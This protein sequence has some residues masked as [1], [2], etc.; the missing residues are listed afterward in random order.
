MGKRKG[1]LRG[2]R[3]LDLTQLYPGPLATMMLADMGAEVVRLEHPSRPDNVHHLPPFIGKE[4]AAYLTLNRSKRSLAL[5]TAKE[6]GRKVFFDL[7]RTADV[8][9]EQFRP[10]VLDKIGIGY[11]QAVPFNSR[12]IYVSITGFGQDGPY[13]QKAGHD[14]NYISLA[15][16]LSQVKKGEEMVLPGFQ[17][18]DV[19]GGGYMSVIACM[20]A[21]WHREKTGKGQRVDVSMTDSV[22]PMITLQLAQ[23]WGSQGDTEIMNPFDGSFPF[24][25]V[26]ECADGKHVSLG[27]LEQKFWSGFCQ[28]ADKPEWLSL[29]FSMGEERRKVREEVAGLFKTKQRNEWLKLAEVHDICLSSIHELGDLEMDPQLQAREM[30]IETEHEKGLKL[31]GIGIPIKF[32]DSKPDKPQPAP[33]VG[34]DSIEILKELG[35]S[36]ERIEELIGKEIVFAQMKH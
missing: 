12:I 3:I 16:L 29:Q 26:Y 31:K 32:S 17:T 36:Q 20:A 15:G 8:V 25:G 30:I 33:I 14:I 34:Q 11:D 2:I 10:G 22:M 19:V 18:A 1:P 9:V 6:E 5:D 35:Y 23:Y 21:L 27:A 13:R 7:V 4:S 28:M 24:Y